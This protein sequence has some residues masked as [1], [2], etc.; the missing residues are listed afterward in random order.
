VLF[1]FALGTAAGDL[2]A[3]R[4]AVGYWKSALIFAALIAVV[5]VAHSR[6]GLNAILAFWV[7][8]IL[9]RPLGASIGDDLSQARPDGGLGLGTTVT[10]TIFL[11]TILVVV[12]YLSITRVDR[13]EMADV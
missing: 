6:F 7:A 11:L 10:S 9:T 4:L 5:F 8:Y 1:T 12:V 2:T 3:E 13:T